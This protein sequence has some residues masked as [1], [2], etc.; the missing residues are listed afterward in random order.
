MKFY[1]IIGC[2][3][4]TVFGQI[5]IKIGAT[6]LKQTSSL[7]KYM[8]NAYIIG[9]LISAVIAAGCWIKALQHYE[10]SY[11]YPFMSLSFVFVVFFSAVLFHESVKVNQWAGLAVVLIG[12]FIGSR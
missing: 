4:F 2:I 9:G 5:L 6:E 3:V 8:L 11:A 1:F 12:L 7:I 10:L